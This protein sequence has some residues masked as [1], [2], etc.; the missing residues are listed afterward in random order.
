MMILITSQDYILRDFW[1]YK[2]KL[3]LF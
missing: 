3:N 1:I 2:D